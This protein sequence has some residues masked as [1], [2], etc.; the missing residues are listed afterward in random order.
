MSKGRW[1]KYCVK[2]RVSSSRWQTM[3]GSQGSRAF[4][5]GFAGGVKH[6]VPSRIVK[7][8]QLG[9]RQQDVRPLGAAKPAKLKYS[10]EK[11]CQ[12]SWHQIIRGSRQYILGFAAA[13][14]R[15]APKGSYR[16]LR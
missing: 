13:V 14:V 8:V 11:L 10:L 15:V 12:P 3:E 5:E 16:V 2:M 7:I 4:A 6:H 1:R 9:K